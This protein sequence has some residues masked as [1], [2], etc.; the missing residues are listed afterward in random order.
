MSSPVV[1]SSKDQKL[2][3]I[4]LESKIVT[5]PQLAQALQYQQEMVVT[6]QRPLKLG[7]ILLFA[8]FVTV[9]QLQEALRKQ[10]G[11]AHASREIAEAA[12]IAKS[13]RAALV[14][15]FS[16]SKEDAAQRKTWIKRLFGK[17]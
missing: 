14:Q 15:S 17:K 13:E 7:Q 3:Q 16:Q 10:V 5:I 2:G 8:G 1:P 9:P 4:L 6:G 11:K 12:K